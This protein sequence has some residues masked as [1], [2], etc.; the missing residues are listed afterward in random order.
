MTKSRYPK[1][2]NQEILSNSRLNYLLKYSF[3]LSTACRTSLFLVAIILS[4]L[5][6]FCSEVRMQ[7]SFLSIIGFI[8]LLVLF[9]IVKDA[10]K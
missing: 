7:A 10:L 4:I 8:L 3:T 1:V 2:K 5:S 9:V 6:R